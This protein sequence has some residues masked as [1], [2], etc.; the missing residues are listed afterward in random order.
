[1]GRRAYP[2]SR[3]LYITADAGGSNGYRSRGWKHELQRFAD[4][5]R[6]TIQVSQF[7]PSTS[8]WNKIEQRLFCHIT[9]NWRDTPPATC[10]TIVDRIGNTRTA[11][12]LR[13]RAALDTRQYPTGVT[14]TKSQM[15]AVALVPDEFNG[16]WHYKLVPR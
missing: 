6:L 16:E 5:T 11:A 1:M 3:G 7:P 13:V 4:R 15:N 9:A 2:N 12:G 8:K 10:E 14:L